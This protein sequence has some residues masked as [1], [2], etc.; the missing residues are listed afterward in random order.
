MCDEVIK[1]SMSKGMGDTSEFCRKEGG[2]IKLCFKPMKV[3]VAREWKN[4]REGVIC[5]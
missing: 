2:K 5:L 1:I 3:A 4:W